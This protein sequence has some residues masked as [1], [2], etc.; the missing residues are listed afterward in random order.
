MKINWKGITKENIIGVAVLLLAL[1]NAIL[2]MLD[3][4]TLPITNEQVSAVVSSV[5]LIATSLYNTYKNR[6]ISSASQIAQQI[7]D[8]IK[9]GELLEEEVKDIIEMLKNKEVI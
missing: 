9:E 4:K 3:I 1:I 2:Q 6:N 8:G 5:F 7:T